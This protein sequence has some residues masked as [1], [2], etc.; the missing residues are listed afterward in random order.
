[1]Y[2]HKSDPV[3]LQIPI[4]NTRGADREQFK[5]DRFNNCKYK[6]SPYYKG[7]ELWKLLPLHIANSHS[8]F[9]FK[10]SFKKEYKTYVDTMY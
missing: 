5:V 8:L 7:S 6:N 10:Q 2:L 3:N 4:R 9:Q 1:M